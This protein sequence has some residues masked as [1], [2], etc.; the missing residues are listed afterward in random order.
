M[1]RRIDARNKTS[2]D[3]VESHIFQGECI[4]R[5][6][7]QGFVATFAGEDYFDALAGQLGNE[8]QRHAGGPDDRFVLMPDQFWERAEKILAADEYFM[9]H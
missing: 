5:I 6:S 8:E 1:P 2:V 9:M 4:A 3:A 7:A